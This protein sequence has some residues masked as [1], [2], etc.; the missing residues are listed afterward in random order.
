MKI[1][2]VCNNA[3]T[4]GNGL[5]ASA[6]NTIKKLREHGQDAR[7]MAAVNPDPSGPQPDFPLEHFIFPFFEPLI[8]ANGFCYAKI[9]RNMIRKAVAWADIVHLE[10][11]FPLENAVRK[12]AVRQ[13]KVCTGTFHLYP[14]NVV[15]NLELGRSRLVNKLLLLYWKRT[16]FDYCSHIQ[17]PTE[18]VREYLD[19]NGFKARLHVISNGL[20]L[21]QTPVKA[22]ALSPEDG[23]YILCTGRLAREKSQ[24]TLLDA[25]RYSR[26][27]DRIRLFFAGNG[28]KARSYARKADKLMRQNILRR[29]VTFMFYPR[30]ELAELARKAYLYVHCAWVEVEGLSCLEATREGAVPVIGTGELVGTSAFALCPESLYPA[31][32]SRALA[33]RIDWWIEHPD[34]RNRMAQLYADA[35]RKYDIDKSIDA[36]IHMFRVAL[37]E[38]G[39]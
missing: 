12:E 22:A 14:H 27:A 34:E 36:L 30:E 18:S 33:S 39:R 29:D 7:L 11:A 25:M 5:S 32:D 21:P 10:E 16:V 15:A 38:A 35:A 37:E 4:P 13:G 26:H 8:R 9:D 6:V 17:C 19:K 31:C 3:Y 20:Q 1:L 2:F 24:G 23:V 28:Q